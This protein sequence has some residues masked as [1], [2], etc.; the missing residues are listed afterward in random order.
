MPASASV[1]LLDVTTS[2]SLRRMRR[3]V[4]MMPLLVVDDEYPTS[5]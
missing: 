4:S 2:C 1:G 5:R 3:S